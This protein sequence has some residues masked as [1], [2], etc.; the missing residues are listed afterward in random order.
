MTWLVTLIISDAKAVIDK[1]LQWNY[2][3]FNYVKMLQ[4]YVQH[5]QFNILISNSVYLSL[6]HWWHHEN[7]FHKLVSVTDEPVSEVKLFIV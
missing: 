2:Y 5:H 1:K 3:V 7:S 4:A 6:S